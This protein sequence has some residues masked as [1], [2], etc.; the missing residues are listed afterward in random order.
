[1]LADWKN[2]EE[3]ENVSKRHE[4]VIISI[5][6]RGGDFSFGV[7]V[8]LKTSGIGFPVMEEPH[9]YKSKRAAVRAAVLYIKEHIMTME[10]FK[11]DEKTILKLLPNVRQGLFDVEEEMRKE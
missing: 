1:M 10:M 5:F 7:N 4:K 11:G 6:S 2:I 9:V 3:I 8:F